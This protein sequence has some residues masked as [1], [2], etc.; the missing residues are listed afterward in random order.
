[1]KLR[2]PGRKRF[3]ESGVSI[4]KSELYIVDGIVGYVGVAVVKVV[5]A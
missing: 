3:G 2:I 4:V 5:S 1:M